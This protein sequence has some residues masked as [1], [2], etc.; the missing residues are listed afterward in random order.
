MTGRAQGRKAGRLRCG[1]YSGMRTKI[2]VNDSHHKKTAV[3]QKREVHGILLSLLFFCLYQRKE[4]R[5]RNDGRERK[6]KKSKVDEEL[7]IANQ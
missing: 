4:G 6:L 3:G 2:L 5:K 7:L 1:A